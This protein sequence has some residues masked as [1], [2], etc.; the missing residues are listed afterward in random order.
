LDGGTLKDVLPYA[1]VRYQKFRASFADALQG[2]SMSR[3]DF[4]SEDFQDA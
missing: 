2:L 4:L 1:K 3:S